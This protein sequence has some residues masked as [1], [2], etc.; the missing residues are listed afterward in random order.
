MPEHD[1]PHH[2]CFADG[3]PFDEADLQV[4][5]AAMAA[6]TRLFDWQIGDVLVCDNLLVMHGRQPY[7]GPRRILTAMG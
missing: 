6:E 2:A 5:R 4:I 7:S 1:F 3:S